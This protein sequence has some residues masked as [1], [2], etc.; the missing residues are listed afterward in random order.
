MI[1]IVGLR[2]DEEEASS[3]DA[4]RNPTPNSVAYSKPKRPNGVAKQKKKKKE[5]DGY[6]KNCMKAIVM[7]RKE[8]NEERRVARSQES[9]AE[10]RRLATEERKV[11]SKE[12]KL[13]ME[14]QVRLLEYEKHLFFLDTSKFDD[15]QKE[16]STFAV[17]SSW[18]K[19]MTGM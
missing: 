17:I 15:R 8:A 6:T 1:E 12:K 3:D 7:E 14:E 10:E 4:K 13:A 5:G 18:S 19:K 11:A 16:Y 9:I 2:D